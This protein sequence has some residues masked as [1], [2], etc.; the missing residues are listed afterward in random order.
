MGDRPQ[1]YLYSLAF[2]ISFSPTQPGHPYMGR[3][4]EYWRWLQLLLE[5]NIEFCVTTNSV[6]F[7]MQ[8]GQMYYFYVDT[9]SQRNVTVKTL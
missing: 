4:S 2:R 3:R 5:K 1:V 9:R 6:L 7:S 8:V